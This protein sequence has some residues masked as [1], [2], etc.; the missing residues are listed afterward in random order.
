MNVFR[1]EVRDFI[2]LAET[3]LS[4]VSLGEPMTEEECQAV[5]FY[6]SALAVTCAA[7]ARAKIDQKQTVQ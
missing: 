6:A 5:D 4:P 1:K 7:Q 3:L 2:R